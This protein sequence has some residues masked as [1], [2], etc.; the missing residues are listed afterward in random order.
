MVVAHSA[1]EEATREGRVPVRRLGW[2]WDL[3][4]GTSKRCLFAFATFL[5]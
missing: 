4:L 5:E 2:Q 1:S 3:H